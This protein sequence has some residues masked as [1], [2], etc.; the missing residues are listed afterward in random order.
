MQWAAILRL[1]C[2]FVEKSYAGEKNASPAVAGVFE[3][4][5]V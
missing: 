4:T 1:S 5:G 3:M 2:R